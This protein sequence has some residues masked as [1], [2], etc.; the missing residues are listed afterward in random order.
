[1]IEGSEFVLGE[2]S[3]A[4]TV[5]VSELASRI[6]EES[7]NMYALEKVYDED[8]RKSNSGSAS[9]AF[10]SQFLGTIRQIPSQLHVLD[11]I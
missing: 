5:T 6:G 1:M 3:K 4:L 2:R 10:A 11:R 9:A 8:Q 7:S